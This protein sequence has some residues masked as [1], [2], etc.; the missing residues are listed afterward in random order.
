MSE[1]VT[2][3]G[4]GPLRAERFKSVVVE[5][6]QCVTTVM[7]TDIDLNPVRAGLVEAPKD[8]KFRGYGN[9]VPTAKPPMRDSAMLSERRLGVVR[10][11]PIDKCSLV[12]AL[13]RKSM[14]RRTFRC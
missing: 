14:G 7:A 1:E 11:T 10:K 8:Y 9:V 13:I 12:E 5:G 3:W 4:K 6:N 2:P